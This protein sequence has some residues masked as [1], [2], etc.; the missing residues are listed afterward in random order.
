MVR[1][2]F[3]LIVFFFEFGSLSQSQIGVGISSGV[4]AL[5]THQ[6]HIESPNNTFHNAVDIVAPQ[7][8]IEFLFKR[9]N[10][11]FGLAT[12][13]NNYIFVG[14]DNSRNILFFPELDDG[15]GS[16]IH[17]AGSATTITFFY[18]FEKTWG[19][20]IGAFGPQ[21]YFSKFQQD[22]ENI[23]GTSESVLDTNFL[24]IWTHSFR[25]WGDPTYSKGLQTFGIGVCPEISFRLFKG[26]YIKLSVE[27]NQGFSTIITKSYKTEF[28]STTEPWKN[29]IYYNTLGSRGSNFKVMYGLHY[30]FELKK[31]KVKEEN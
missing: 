28:W 27:Y 1:S 14:R 29:A 24:P 12:E 18:S 9:N 15:R 2:T 7:L 8:S 11:V 20:V 10:S 3:G 26:L 17:N 25:E 23:G 19:R 22:F 31:K 4:G 21:I 30:R 6:V 5:L 13:K 16:S